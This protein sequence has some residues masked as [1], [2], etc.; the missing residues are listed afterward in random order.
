MLKTFF[1]LF[2]FLTV[3]LSA[4]QV[5]A[6]KLKTEMHYPE[7]NFQVQSV[8][9]SIMTLDDV[10][11]SYNYRSHDSYEKI[12]EISLKYPLKIYHEQKSIRVI[13]KNSIDK[14]ELQFHLSFKEKQFYPLMGGGL[15]S[16]VYSLCQN[17]FEQLK[18]EMDM[19]SGEKLKAGFHV[20]D[21]SLNVIDPKNAL[22]VSSAQVPTQKITIDSIYLED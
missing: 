17:I 11:V 1:I 14:K 9:E 12:W 18:I 8:F 7:L 19:Q 2:I 4:E 3:P 6:C 15:R 5:V 20:N 21:K 10:F 22:G 13:M 16:L